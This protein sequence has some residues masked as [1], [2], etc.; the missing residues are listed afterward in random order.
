[1]RERRW[2]SLAFLA[3]TGAGLSGCIDGA[4]GAPQ[5]GQIGGV[6]GSEGGCDDEAEDIGAGV[7]SPLGFSAEDVIAALSGER[8]APLAWAKGGSTT[9]TVALGEPVSAR[10]VR[11]KPGEWSGPGGA[12]PAL[13]VDCSDHLQIDVPLA[14]STEDGAFDETFTV[15]LRAAQ[16][17]AASFYH[18]VDL[19]A[20]EGSYEVTE[21]DPAEFREV[22]VYLSGTLSSSAV[23]GRI[24]GVAESH[25]S[26]SGPDATVSARPFDVAEF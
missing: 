7:A 21:V 14:F 13:A 20:L 22:I 25:P 2:L 23:T 11:S 26:G 9:A 1:M 5:G 19:D 6:H 12:E 10:F 4:G 15:T 16:V 18:K 24:N 3:V 8:S 17:D